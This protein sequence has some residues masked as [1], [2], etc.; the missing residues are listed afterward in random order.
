[1]LLP[2]LVGLLLCVPPPA[3]AQTRLSLGDVAAPLSAPSAVSAPG[4]T[5]APSLLSPAAIVPLLPASF[6]AAPVVAPLTNLAQ[7]AAGVEGFSADYL[8]PDR[9]FNFAPA[10][11]LRYR[12]ALNAYKSGEDTSPEAAKTLVDSAFDLA[13]SAGIGVE[14]VMRDAPRGGAHAGLRVLPLKGATPLNRLAYDLDRRYG[15][16]IEYVPERIAGGVAAYN[17]WS[18]VLFLPDFGRPDAFEAVLHETAHAEFTH[19]LSQGDVSPFH[20]QLVAYDGR[21]VAPGASVY[22][23]HMSLEEIFTHGKEIKH[24]LAAAR[25]DGSA[26]VASLLPTYTFI[27]QYADV[28]R[29]ARLN[30]SQ[31][32]ALVKKGSASVRLA[33][34]EPEPF[35]GGRWYVVAL[36][37]GRFY[38]P[39]KLEVEPKRG[40]LKRTFLP[41]PETAPE[42][43]LYR[44]AD[45]LLKA[46]AEIDASLID[47]ETGIKADEPDLKALNAAADRIVVSLSRAEK[48]F[49]SP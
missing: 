27:Y 30:L 40:F 33:E 17:S 43:A 7:P 20:G 10:E 15:A 13:K 38:F 45:V 14:P 19:R 34:N 49:S 4:L 46:I 5:A 42:R 8:R 1:M 31:A 37:Y 9:P 21:A 35:P 36:P 32:R 2:A 41:A 16:K 25:R 29:S 44:R 47:L 6:A 26:S 3:R 39:A 22:V 48:A 18:K 23:E 24:R 28:L 11:T 12:V